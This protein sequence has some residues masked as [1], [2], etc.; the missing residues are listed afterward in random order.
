MKV[1]FNADEHKLFE[2]ALH[3]SAQ[4]LRTVQREMSN[5]ALNQATMR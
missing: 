2:E 1:R 5:S 4:R 3:Q